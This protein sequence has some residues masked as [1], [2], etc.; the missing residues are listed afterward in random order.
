MS[1]RRGGADARPGGAAA[2]KQALGE[3]RA[4]TPSE[5]R[6][7]RLSAPSS[8]ISVGGTESWKKSTPGSSESLRFGAPSTRRALAATMGGT[9]LKDY[10]TLTWAYGPYHLV[11]VQS[12]MLCCPN[13]YGS[14]GPKE[15]GREAVSQ[16][17]AP[18]VQALCRPRRAEALRER[19]AAE[20]GLVA[21]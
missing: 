12:E 20:V 15:P 16:S 5:E 2:S 3:H 4:W 13:F 10:M 17:P 18:I 11:G 19:H 14:F 6:V 9:S 1:T 21:T 7:V 8:G